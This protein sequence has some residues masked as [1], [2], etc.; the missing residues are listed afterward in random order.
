MRLLSDD[1]ALPHPGEPIFNVTIIFK[2][3]YEKLKKSVTGISNQMLELVA[4]NDTKR[5]VICLRIPQRCPRPNP[6]NL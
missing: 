2:P 5:Q 6:W 3:K 1:A 4:R